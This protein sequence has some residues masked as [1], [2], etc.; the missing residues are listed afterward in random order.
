MVSLDQSER[1]LLLLCLGRWDLPGKLDRLAHISPEEWPAVVSLAA[2]LNV[3]PLL[4]HRLDQMGILLPAPVAEST[5]QELLRQTA[6]NMRLYN[7]LENLLGRLAKEGIP[8]MILKGTYLA[9]VVYDD[10]GLRFIGDIDLLIHAEDSEKTVDLLEI[11][12]FHPDRPFWPEVDGAL[13]YHAPPMVKNGLQVELHW[14]LT[15]KNDPVRINPEDLWARAQPINLQAREV[16][17]LSL[18][19]LVLHLAVHAAYV[20]QFT[21][22]F[23]SLVDI[24]EVFGKFWDDLDWVA[25]TQTCLDWHAERG[26][27]LTLRLVAELFGAA[28]P[29][30][31]LNKIKPSDWSEQ[32]IEWAKVRLFQTNPVLSEN[33]IRV[34]H[35]S[36]LTEK[37]AALRKGLFPSRAVMATL[38]G[39][40]PTSWRILAL[41][42]R[43]ASTRLKRYRKYA[44]NLVR[45]DRD[46]AIESVSDQSLRDWLGIAPR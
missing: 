9:A 17:A 22:Q 29:E 8:V 15:R 16:W 18:S 26:T 20:H 11:N 25:I 4:R 43:H 45:G 10:I 36:H 37:L 39:V 28:M 13:H 38:Y 30:K 46:Q 44:W 12:D 41:Y 7:E 21:A 5:K 14:N 24:A 33:F 42:P 34:M 32:V 1:T 2:Q 6:R 19:D 3:M 31:V 35:G 23:R 27:Y 40:P